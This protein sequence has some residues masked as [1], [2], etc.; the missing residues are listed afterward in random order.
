MDDVRNEDDTPHPHLRSDLFCVKEGKFFECRYWPVVK[1]VNLY[2]HLLNFS[3]WVKP[4]HAAT[5]LNV[6]ILCPID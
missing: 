3:E 5:T 1:V 4:D 2:N 6:R